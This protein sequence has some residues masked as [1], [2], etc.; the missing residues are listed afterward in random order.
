[1]AF[2]K[3]GLPGTTAEGRPSPD[4]AR[5][6]FGTKAASTAECGQ[7]SAKIRAVGDSVLVGLVA[8]GNFIGHDVARRVERWPV[9]AITDG[10]VSDIPGSAIGA[11]PREQS[12]PLPRH[13]AEPACSGAGPW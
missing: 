6:A 1:M 5:S 7:L 11:S 4:G 12:L 13:T 3:S 9:L 2:Y 8:T 10:V